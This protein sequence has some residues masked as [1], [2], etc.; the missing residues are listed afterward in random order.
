MDKSRCHAIM[1]ELRNVGGDLEREDVFDCFVV[2]EKMRM[3]QPLQ[4]RASCT[5]ERRYAI[6]I[7]HGCYHL[8]PPEL[9]VRTD[10]W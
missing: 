1:R 8:A 10:E 9:R 5:V 3:L 6:H 4:P 7:G 2:K